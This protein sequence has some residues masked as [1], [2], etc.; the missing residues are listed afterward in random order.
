MR[1][2]IVFKDRTGFVSGDTGIH[3]SITDVNGE[4]LDSTEE[5]NVT[6]LG[7]KEWNKLQKMNH[8]EIKKDLK[9]IKEKLVK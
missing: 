2:L 6:S 8:K 9:N 3:L 5:I 4:V 1:K 7:K